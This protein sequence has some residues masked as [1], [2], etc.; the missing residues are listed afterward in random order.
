[1]T[2]RTVYLRGKSKAQLNRELA[3]GKL[4]ECVAYDING[5][6]VFDLEKMPNGTVVKIYEKEVYG[7]PYAKAYGNVARKADG[8]VYLK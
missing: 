1:M 6:D 8:R 4:F 2:I 3:A 7:S 5:A